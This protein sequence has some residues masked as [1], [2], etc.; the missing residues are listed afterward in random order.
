MLA[1]VILGL[2]S[3]RMRELDSGSFGLECGGV[4][5]NR[6]FQGPSYVWKTLQ[7]SY[8]PAIDK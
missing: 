7:A 6:I 2:Q 8:N 3:I 1:F 5:F 4:T